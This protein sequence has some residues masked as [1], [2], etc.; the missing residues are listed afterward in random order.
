VLKVSEL[1]KTFDDGV[2]A[3]ERLSLDVEPGKFFT[4]LGPSGCG[5]TTTL[6]CIAGLERPDAGEIVV[7][8]RLLFSSQARVAVPASER[9]LGMV[10]QS[11]AIWPHMTVFDT[12]AFPLIVQPRRRR[13]SRREISARVERALAVVKLDRLAGRQASDLSGGEQ[14]RLAL[15]RALILEPALILMDEPLSNLDAQLREDMRFELKRLQHELGIT[16]VY[17]THDQAEALALSNVVAVMR[18]GRVEQ[19]GKP[20]QIYEAPG[21]RFVAEFLGRSNLIEGVVEEKGPEGSYVISTREGVLTA[22]CRGDFAVGARVV[23]SVRA[24]Q[25]AVSRGRDGQPPPNSWRGTVKAR[26][27]RGDSI[28]HVVTVGG[29]ELRARCDSSTS[30]RPDTEVLVSLPAEACSLFDGV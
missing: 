30:I 22:R 21:S 23:V 5:K 3:V 20:R 11:Y 14:Q 1:V 7:A 29:L 10:F 27:F 6:R 28:D 2:V 13:P 4:L 26:A 24:D 8:G 25:V 19:V 15:A 18:Q 16:T 9:G 12:A 17:V